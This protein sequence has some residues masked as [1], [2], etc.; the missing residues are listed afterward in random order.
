MGNKMATSIVEFVRAFNAK[1]GRGCPVGAIEYVGGFS[2]KDIKTAKDKGQIV[3][4]KGTDGGFFPA[5]EVVKTSKAKVKDSL[6][7]DMVAFI[8]AVANGNGDAKMVETA[9][10]LVARYNAECEKKKVAASNRKT[11]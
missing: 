10:A 6:K 3:S 8:T 4:T 5:G 11:K 7:A 2:K 1:E 9:H